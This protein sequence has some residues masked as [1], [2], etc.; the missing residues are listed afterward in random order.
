MSTYN[1][2]SKPKKSAN[3]ERPNYTSESD[4]SSV[5]DDD[6]K[7]QEELLDPVEQGLP[8]AEK[9][10]APE[11]Q[12]DRDATNDEV[13]PTTGMSPADEQVRT[14]LGLSEEAWADSGHDTRRKRQDAGAGGG[15]TV[16]RRPR[17]TGAN[18]G[19]A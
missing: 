10:H 13:S 6:G 9:R 3:D 14:L 5:N 4:E 2:R 11:Q 18:L 1:T 19:F 17:R 8:E 16:E 12:N 7:R 15:E